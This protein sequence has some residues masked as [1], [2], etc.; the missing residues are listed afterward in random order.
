VGDLNG[1]LEKKLNE[2]CI[3]YEVYLDDPQES[4]EQGAVEVSIDQVIKIRNVRFTNQSFPHCRNIK[5]SDYVDQAEAEAE[6]GLTVQWKS[7]CTYASAADRHQNV[8]KERTSEHIRANETTGQFAIS[9]ATRRF[10]WRGETVRGGAY[11][12][13]MGEYESID[14]L[15]DSSQVPI[16]L[17]SGSPELERDIERLCSPKP[18]QKPFRQSPTTANS[19]T[20]LG[21]RKH[22]SDEVSYDQTKRLHTINWRPR[23]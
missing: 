22:T 19:A 12:P 11:R 14:L 8:Y 15:E 17:A 13:A 6:G 9:D 21:K 20:S 23:G 16:S 4:Q 1:M 7:T 2:V 5:V 3:C 18:P 10:E